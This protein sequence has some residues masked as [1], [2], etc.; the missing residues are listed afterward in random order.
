MKAIL[1]F[2][3]PEDY[4]DFEYASKGLD[5]H[6]LIDTLLSEM[7]QIIKYEE[8]PDEVYNIVERL[9]DRIVE[10]MNERGIRGVE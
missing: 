1:E 9:R 5:A 10:E 8:H 3:L 2:N 7:R 6:L 4:S